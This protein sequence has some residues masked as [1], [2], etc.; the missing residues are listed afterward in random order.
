MQPQ[1]K[2]ND[3]TIFDHE[4]EYMDKRSLQ[5]PLVMY[6]ISLVLNIVFLGLL[7]MGMFES[8][9]SPWE[10]CTV[11]G[12]AIC[13]VFSVIYVMFPKSKLARSTLTK[14]FLVL[15]GVYSVL[16]VVGVILAAFLI[17]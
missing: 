13:T 11:L 15:F 9:S 8:N 2:I 3:L 1:E 14:V 5:C 7:S 12:G 17:G 10:I 16:V 6:Y 4:M